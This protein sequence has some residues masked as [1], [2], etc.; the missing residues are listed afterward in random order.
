MH[1]H[2]SLLH[3]PAVPPYFALW[4]HFIL[5]EYICLGLIHWYQD[6]ILC[7]RSPRPWAGTPEEYTVS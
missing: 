7:F 5:I 4:A 1:C 3:V 6:Q 2:E